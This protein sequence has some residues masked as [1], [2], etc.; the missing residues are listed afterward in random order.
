MISMVSLPENRHKEARSDQDTG[1]GQRTKSMKKKMSV[2]QKID[3]F[4][5]RNFQGTTDTTSVPLTFDEITKMHYNKL[6]EGGEND[7]FNPKHYLD[8]DDSEDE[9]LK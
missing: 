6:N 5:A 7:L 1:T 2:I 3:E 8:D 4:K 9:V